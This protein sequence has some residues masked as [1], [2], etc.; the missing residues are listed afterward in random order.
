M[1][2]RRTFFDRKFPAPP[3][4]PDGMVW[5]KYRGELQLVPID[6]LQ[7]ACRA[8][9]DEYDRAPKETRFQVAET[10]NQGLK[11]QL[12]EPNP[13]LRSVGIARAR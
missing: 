11:T 10:G 5:A 6:K 9:M 2:R 7:A 1:R 13:V 4:T 8:N 3:P 12:P